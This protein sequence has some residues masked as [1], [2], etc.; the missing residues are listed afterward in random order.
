VSMRIQL[1]DAATKLFGE[2]GYDGTSLQQVSDTVGIRKPSLLYHFHSKEDLR[3][4]V[5]ASILDHWKD[6]VPQILLAATT[7]EHRFE[8]A[9]EHVIEF[10][11]SVPARAQFFLRE[12]LDRPMAM[13]KK[14]VRALAPW[15]AMAADFIDK[16]RKEGVVHSD[17]DAESYILHLIQLIVSSVALEEA[18]QALLSDGGTDRVRMRKELVRLTHRALFTEY[19]TK[20][21][22]DD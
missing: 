17:V 3:E 5:M 15:I 16:G 18:G 20:R 6:T 19:P 11:E 22:A 4:A 1:I 2:K 21:I 12:A 9:T 7:G 14:L 8:A 13:R 10:F